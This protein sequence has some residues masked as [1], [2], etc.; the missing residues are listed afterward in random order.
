[1]STFATRRLRRQIRLF[2]MLATIPLT[3]LRGQS[4][5]SIAAPAS[6]GITAVQVPA[7]DI[8]S[9]KPNKTGSGH[10]SVHIDDGNLDA[11]NISIKGLMFDAYGLKEGQ[12]VG[13]P[14]WAESAR[15]DIKAKVLNPDKAVF[16][17]LTEERSRS[18]LQP[19]LTD[20]FQLKSHTEPKVLPVYEL[21]VLKGGPKFK[22]SPNQAGGDGVSVHN[23][24]LTAHN[25]T[26]SELMDELSSQVQ[27]VVIDKTGL[28]AKYDL[29]LKWSAEDAPPGDADAPP[30]I[31]TAI[32]EQ[33]G[34]KLV[35]GKASV[36]T[37]VIDHL[38]MPS[39][40]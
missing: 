23:R 27:R 4:V 28:T 9:I 38:E 33:L 7:Y 39:E 19:I 31:F 16:A 8:V 24:D 14:G 6:P 37:L 1:M 2:L 15:F 18:M 32:Q 12:L 35:A 26:I 11:S 30:S 17:K 29:T 13:L 40:N 22:P 21:V 34:L 36:S 25:I 5:P 10:T 3:A 20:R